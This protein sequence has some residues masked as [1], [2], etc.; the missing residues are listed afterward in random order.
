M[1][2]KLQLEFIKRILTDTVYDETIR[3][4]FLTENYIPSVSTIIEIIKSPVFEVRN[5]GLDWPERA[6]T[7]IGLKRLNNLHE[8][9]D[10]IRENNIAGDFIETG[11]WRGGAS[12]FMSYYNELY[13]MKRKVFV[14]D[15]FEGLPVPDITKYPVDLGDTHH[16][17]DFLKVS[18]EEV[19]NNFALYD[20]LTEHVIFI[21][22]WFS[23]TLKNNELINDISLLRFDGDMYGSTMDVLENIYEKLVSKGIL[24][25]DDYCLPNCVRAVHDF[26]LKHNISNEIKIIDSCGVYWYK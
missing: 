11:V 6:H 14:V 20:V 10:Y 18:I 9:L 21:K 16:Q 22:G 13:N 26:R 24:I 5:N 23:E 25:I 15:S 7:M 4:M 2:E 8:S 19:K 12:I 1:S 17:V 3:N